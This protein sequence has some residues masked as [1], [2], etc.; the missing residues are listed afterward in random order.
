[1]G[2]P[3]GTVVKYSPA[4]AGDA[5]DMGLIPWSRRSPG[6][7][8]GNLLQ[9]ACLDDSM[10]RGAHGLQ[11]MGSQKSWTLWATEHA[12]THTHTHTWW[13]LAGYFFKTLAKTAFQNSMWHFH[14]LPSGALITPSAIISKYSH[15]LSVIILYIRMICL[16]SVQFSFL[17]VS[18]SLRPHESQHSRPPC[19]SP[20]PGVQSN[21]CASS[22]WCHPAISFSVIP[23]SS[24]PQPLPASGSF[25]LICLQV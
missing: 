8:N 21:S 14:S 9:Y 13:K 23:F 20:T 24:C 6:V 11:S 3:C 17:V 5:K 7:G 16:S 15:I 19:P 22:W 1:M 10:D 2:F 18:N 25:P 12:H 4:N